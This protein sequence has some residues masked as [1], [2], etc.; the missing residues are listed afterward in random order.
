MSS[1]LAHNGIGI[2]IAEI[3]LRVVEEKGDYKELRL[4]YWLMGALGGLIP[5]LDV[6]FFVHHLFTHTLLA[7]VILVVF[8]VVNMILLPE[9]YKYSILISV[10]FLFHLFLDFIDNSIL[11]FSPFNQSV[12]WGLNLFAFVEKNG[13]GVFV[14]AYFFTY[15][16]LAI[17]IT[18]AIAISLFIY[19][20]YKIEQDWA[21]KK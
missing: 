12:E 10:G 17:I 16:D 8:M 13:F 15:Y 3:L 14:L 11:P 7:V 19:D 9:A 1:I 18:T 4:F 21:I 5:D 6:L 2:L 20:R